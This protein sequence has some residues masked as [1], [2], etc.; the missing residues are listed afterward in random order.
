M[1]PNESR[2]EPMHNTATPISPLQASKPQSQPNTTADK[3]NRKHHERKS[4][5][6]ST[7]RWTTSELVFPSRDL[8]LIV[9]G[10]VPS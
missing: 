10:K 8:P 5:E 9:K 4:K 7:P 3:N 6:K 2:L 1:E